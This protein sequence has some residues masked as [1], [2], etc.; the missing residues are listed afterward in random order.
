[1]THYHAPTRDMA[2]VMQ[3]LLNLNAIRNRPGFEEATP[4]LVDAIIEQAA[5]FASCVLAPLNRIGDQQGATLKD[6]VVA[7]A[8]GF[9]QAY[10]QFVEDGWNG[11]SAPADFE[12]QGLPSLIATATQEMWQSA[13]MAFALCPLL[14]SSAIEALRQHGSPQQQQHY[15][16]KL[17]SGHWTGTMNLTE[18]Q[19][20]SDLA[21]VR[22]RATPQD[23][24]FLIKGQKIY[25]T[26]GEHDCAENIIHLVLART[27]GAPEGVKGISL[28]IVPK[29][30]LDT[31]GNPGDRNDLRCVSLEHKLG[32]HGSPTCTMAFGDRDGAVGYLVG[33]EGKGLNY[34]FTMMNEARH[35]VGVQGLSIADRAY[36]QAR[37]FANERIQ[38]QPVGSLTDERLSII[39]HPD[40]RRM[41]LTM[42]AQNEAMRALCYDVAWSMD[43]GVPRTVPKTDASS[44]QNDDFL[45]RQQARVD[46]LIPVV[47][48]WCTEVGVEVASLGIQI[49][50]GMGYVEETGAAQH[51]RDARIT[52]IYEGT[53]GIQAADLVGRKIARDAGK[54]M[55][56]EIDQ[57]QAV[58][59]EL[60][61]ATDP[62][63]LA[64]NK[65]LED[66]IKALIETTDW[67]VATHDENPAAVA[68][69]SVPYLMLAG[70]VLAGG[71]MARSAIIAIEALVNGSQETDF[72]TTKRQMARF[73]AAHILPKATALV[74]AIKDAHDSVLSI[75]VDAL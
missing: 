68:A 64:I 5:R 9:P 54:A 66:G 25:I 21:A 22:T 17:V 23:T 34:M 47:K 26:W 37:D 40:V 62:N 39:Y 38:G 30:L 46:L 69:A 52:T 35:K 63:L 57:L 24:H 33:E 44:S 1:M 43:M 16:P 73:Y 58:S 70:Y 53:T 51:L 61:N 49:H 19:A 28:F 36:Q 4:E 42:R 74:P 65:A 3:E 41:L 56:A 59:D 7:T 13:N 71:L 31:H 10:R 12:G 2:F 75:N 14:T 32:I 20:G 55:K 29:F 50:G 6:G 72:Y 60:G 11:L 18:P 48:G 67:V 45:K 27:P 15:L 8:T